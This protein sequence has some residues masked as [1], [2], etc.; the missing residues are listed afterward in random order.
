MRNGNDQMPARNDRIL[1]HWVGAHELHC[2]NPAQAQAA[3]IAVV[4]QE[5]NLSSNLSVAEN[6]FLG[7]EP[8]T[9]RAFVD[10]KRLKEKATE[11]LRKLDL[12]FDQNV[13]VGHMT[14]GQ[15]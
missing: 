6:I 13:I 11:I 4:Y 14:V 8:R 12:H 3:G 7:M 9:A 15:Q 5:L 1:G 10:R 2:A